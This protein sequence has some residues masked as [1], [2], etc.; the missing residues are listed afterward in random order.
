MDVEAWTESTL[1]A[2]GKL[3]L[4]SPSA[5]IRGTSVSLSIPL[6]SIAPTPV[7]K[8]NADIDDEGVPV[9]GLPPLRRKTSRRDSMRRRDALLMGKEGSRRRQKWENGIA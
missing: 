2:I 4:A 5:T 7:V 3:S 1:K 6:D 9:G 8:P